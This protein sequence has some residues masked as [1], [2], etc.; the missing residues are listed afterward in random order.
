[1]MKNKLEWPVQHDYI[2]FQTA[3][4]VFKYLTRK[5]KGLS[6][7]QLS[8][9]S[10]ITYF[11]AWKEKP[12]YP[13]SSSRDSVLGMIA[14]ISRNWRDTPGAEPLLWNSRKFTFCSSHTV[15]KMFSHDA[16]LPWSSHCESARTLA[17]IGNR[18]PQQQHSRKSR[19]SNMPPTNYPDSLPTWISEEFIA[20]S[21]E[22]FHRSEG[23]ITFLWHTLHLANELTSYSQ[24]LMN[25]ATESEPG[26]ASSLDFWPMQLL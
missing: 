15:H 7:V 4:T 22:L 14:D 24:Y 16:Q 21:Q 26:K 10:T 13:A 2:C 18:W 11:R 23:D 6:K 9:R 1:M 19:F 12:V 25:S 3:F 20:Q 17:P 5:P 8:T